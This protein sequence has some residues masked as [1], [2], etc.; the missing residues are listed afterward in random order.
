MSDLLTEYIHSYEYAQREEKRRE[1]EERYKGIDE[2]ISKKFEQTIEDL[3]AE[4][5]SR[6]KNKRY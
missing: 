6:K 3:K 1:L 2:H 4:V 5:L